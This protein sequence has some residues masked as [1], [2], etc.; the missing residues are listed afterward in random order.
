MPCEVTTDLVS[1]MIRTY[2]ELCQIDSYVDRFE[3]LKLEGSVGKATFGS[4][5]YLN[6]KFYKSYEWLHLRDKIITRD[7][8]RDLGVFGFDIKGPIHIHHMNPMLVQ[9]L[10]EF[11]PDIMNPEYLISTSYQTHKAIHYSN[12][13]MLVLPPVERT[14]NDTCPWKV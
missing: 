3:Y 11:N 13:D 6:Q 2:S 10:V 9:D 14:P 8:G 7:L 5:R 12:A 1:P 4:K